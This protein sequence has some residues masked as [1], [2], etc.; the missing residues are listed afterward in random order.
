MP[1]VDSPFGAS[2]AS[3]GADS[4]PRAGGLMYAVA[5]PV[6]RRA[7][8]GQ[9]CRVLGG[10]AG[11]SDSGSAGL[12]RGPYSARILHPPSLHLP[13]A[14]VPRSRRPQQPQLPQQGGEDLSAYPSRVENS[15]E[16]QHTCPGYLDQHQHQRHQRP[17]PTAIH[18]QRSPRT[19]SQSSRLFN[20]R[21]WSGPAELFYI[22][23]PKSSGSGRAGST[24]RISGLLARQSASQPS[25]KPRAVPRPA[26]GTERVSRQASRSRSRHL[27]SDSSSSRALDLR[28]AWGVPV[29]GK[30]ASPRGQMG[31]PPTSGYCHTCRKRRIKCGAYC[32]CPRGSRR[33]RRRSRSSRPGWWRG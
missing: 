2:G 17:T 3:V 20:G 8:L 5:H 21:P 32:F 28:R 23:H 7:A 16:Q 27:P 14:P 18:N 11:V 13:S 25:E 26:A 15:N 9:L 19:Q 31:R 29:P 6:P 10:V 1:R 30:S 4:R 33:R 24:L 12:G 22:G